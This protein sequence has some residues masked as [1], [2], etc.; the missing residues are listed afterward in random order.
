[1]FHV[2]LIILDQFLLANGGHLHLYN[3]TVQAHTRTHT[4]EK[5]FTCPWTDCGCKFSRSDELTRHKRK[6]LGLKPFICNICERAFSRYTWQTQFSITCEKIKSQKRPLLATRAL[7]API[8]NSTF[9]PNAL[10]K[11]KKCF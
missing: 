11:P 8:I 3:P 4:G 10:K 2:L 6:H 1:M 9:R 7:K 5:P